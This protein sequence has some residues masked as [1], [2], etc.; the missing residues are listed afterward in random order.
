MKYFEN[1]KNNIDFFIRKRLSFSRKNYFELNEDKEGLFEGF[2]NPQKALERE[3]FLYEKYELEFLKSNSTKQNYLENFYII[4]ILDKYFTS[5]FTL[6]AS[7]EN[8][9]PLQLFTPSALD[10][11]CKNWFYA[12]GEWAFFKKH[13]DILSLEGIELD[14]NRLYSN[15]YSRKEAA[16]FYIKGL[17]NT[18]YIEGDFLK[19]NKTYDYMVWI[20]PF[21]VENPLLK[22]GLP[23]RYF[24]PEEML[25]KAYDLLKNGGSMLILNQGQVEHDIQVMLCE[26][27]NIPYTTYG[28]VKSDFLNYN[29]PRYLMLIT[30]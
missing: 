8:P 14:A 1:I 28:E 6:H 18:K 20:L 7:P 5:R 27:L 16:R 22:W 21:V 2:Q 26:K 25:K 24:K 13:Y 17:E 19:H 9:S 3:K 12:K 4:D 11:G 15:F 29:I 30:K 23:L 10:I